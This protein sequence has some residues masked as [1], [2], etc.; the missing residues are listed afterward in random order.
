[1][2]CPECQER[3]TATDDGEFYCFECV[4]VFYLRDTPPQDDTEREELDLLII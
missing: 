4:K 1:M 2:R 3:L